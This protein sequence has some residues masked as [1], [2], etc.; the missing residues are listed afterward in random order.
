MENKNDKNGKKETRKRMIRLRNE[1][2]K[3][4]AEE[5]S[6]SICGA[7]E[8]TDSYRE[9]EKLCIYMPVN[10]EVDV[11]YLIEP[12]RKCGKSLWLPKVQGKEMDFLAY[13]EDT[14]LVAGAFGIPEPLY[15]QEPLRSQESLS[16]QGSLR[17]QELMSSQEL[18]SSQNSLH[19]HVLA[20]DNKR[21]TGDMGCRDELQ[22][23]VLVPDSRTLVIMPGAVFSEQRGR[24]GYGGGYYD[25]FLQKYTECM[26]LAVCYDFQI[27]PE[28]QTEAHD[29]KPAVVVSEKRMLI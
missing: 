13:E 8:M 23:C 16:S 29:I 20:P 9:A 15:S 22:S 25:R 2:R 10:N 4:K 3:E 19:S 1:L 14:Q 7:V 12:A 27:L 11:R 17:S 24:I 18:L 26:T 6:R 21:Y 5:L 28:V